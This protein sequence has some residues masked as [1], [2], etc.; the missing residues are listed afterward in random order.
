VK[1]S[2]V[3]GQAASAVAASQAQFLGWVI[4]T[5]PQSSNGC[6]TTTKRNP[7]PEKSWKTRQLWDDSHLTFHHV[8]GGG[9]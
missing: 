1:T 7:K 3:V 2:F 4:H 8:Q 9:W 6:M 5:S